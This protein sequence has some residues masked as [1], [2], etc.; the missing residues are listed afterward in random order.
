MVSEGFNTPVAIWVFQNQ[1]F[2]N[3]KS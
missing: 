1:G 2:N 3:A